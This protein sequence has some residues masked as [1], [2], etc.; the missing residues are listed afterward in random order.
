MSETS[1]IP[2][3]ALKTGNAPVVLVA[4]D[5]VHTTLMLQRVFEHE[6]YRVECVYDGLTTLE[7]ARR[8]IPDLLLLDIQMP[9]MNGFEVLTELRKD[10]RTANIPTIMI[11]AM[12]GPD[13]VA[14]GMN[15]GADD[16]IPKPFHPRELLARAASKM[17]ARKL[18]DALQR[19][20][21]ELEAL[22][23]VSETLNQ[24]IEREK[25]LNLIPALTLKLL[26][27]QM[28][29]V[30]QLQENSKHT[31]H[32][33]LREDTSPIP[34]LNVEA[35]LNAFELHDRQGHLWSSETP[36]PFVTQA[37]G[38]VIVPLE[39][40]VRLLGLLLISGNTAYDNSHLRLLNGIGRQGSLALRNAELLEI[41][42][43]YAL[44]LED[45]VAART[46][47]LEKAQAL[48]IRSEKL[49]SIG[50]L[51]ASIAHE[52]NNPLQPIRLYLDGMLESAQNNL[53]VD[54]EDIE[55]TQHSVERI[56][57]I[58]SRLL[59][60]TRNEPPAHLNVNSII[61]NIVSLNRKLFQ[62]A[63]MEIVTD[64]GS[65][66]PVYGNRDQLEQVFINLA[67][68][69]KAAMSAGGVLQIKTYTD[70]EDVV[71]LFQD[72]GCGIPPENINRVFDAFFS[73]KAD[74]GTGLGL[75]VSHGIIQN[76]HGALDVT[77]EMNVGT[78]FTI[79]IPVSPEEE[80]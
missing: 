75:F 73:T 27:G 37:A 52:I 66:P 56:T 38:A 30:V 44:H 55:H 53:P 50:Q 22:L 12:D 51:A 39:H 10:T 4:D 5:Q 17:R 72:N 21:E 8:L 26:P 9:G 36:I 41:Q 57:R 47:E 77:S 34:E 31:Q 80:E 19:R 24:N 70:K 63:N 58:V 13:N 43:N 14:Q 32:Y 76:H 71:I 11:T 1:V 46:K 61:E 7:A 16:F 18:E 40:D 6:G 35:L 33:A 67:L 69:A 23:Y 78:T 28:A 45:M 54:L 2:E 48:L 20:T 60:F 62:H 59:E 79:R 64:L 15:L 65:V 42:A 3:E 29:A 49:A 25:L 68:N 74:Q